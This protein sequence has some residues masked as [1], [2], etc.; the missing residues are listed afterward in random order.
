MRVDNTAGR[1][2][3]FDLCSRYNINVPRSGVHRF[4][5]VDADDPFYHWVYH[6]DRW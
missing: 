1:R 4:E 5:L 3:W 2:G 6:L